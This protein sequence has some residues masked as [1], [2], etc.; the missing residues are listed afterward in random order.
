MFADHGVRVVA[1]D[2][3]PQ[4]NLTA[5]FLDEEHVEPLW[6]DDG[7]T[8]TVYGAIRPLLRGIGDVQ[9]AHVEEIDDAIGLVVGTWRCPA[10]RTS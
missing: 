1:A 7:A 10:S 3:D 5:A 2:L 9:P 6:S 8:P 4:A